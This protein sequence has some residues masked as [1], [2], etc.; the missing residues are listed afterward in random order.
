[1]TLVPL[2]PQQGHAD[3]AARDGAA[4][5]REAL[6]MTLQSADGRWVLVQR[7]GAAAELALSSAAGDGVATD[8]IDRTFVEKGTRW[9]IDYK[10]AQKV[11]TPRVLSTGRVGDTAIETHADQFRP[12]LQRYARLFADEGL[13]VRFAVFY[14]ALGRLVELEA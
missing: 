2:T 8:V 4:R 1:M 7:D 6:R 3:A 13:P 12:Q 9:I 11:G 5:A 14:A 10:T